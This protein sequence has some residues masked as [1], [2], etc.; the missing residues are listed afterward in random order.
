MCFLPISACR[1]LE[2]LGHRESIVPKRSLLG[3]SLSRNDNSLQAP[4]RMNVLTHAIISLLLRVHFS[5]RVELL[6]LELIYILP[7]P[8]PLHLVGHWI[9]STGRLYLLPL[10]E[11]HLSV[12]LSRI[13]VVA[14]CHV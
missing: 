4:L 12:F 7:F 2:V 6:F 8:A 1:E 10:S 3:L 5:L 11:R 9:E 14:H 13:R